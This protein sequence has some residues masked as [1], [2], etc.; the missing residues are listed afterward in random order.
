MHLLNSDK[1]YKNKFRSFKTQI[2]KIGKPVFI[3]SITTAIGFLSFMFSSL[4][5]LFRFGVITTITIFI[6]LFVIVIL[7]SLIID[8][9]INNPGIYAAENTKNNEKLRYSNTEAVLILFLL[10]KINEFKDLDKWIDILCKQQKID[11][12]W[13]NGYNSYFI[14]DIKL[15]FEIYLLISL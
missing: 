11:G 4:I 2:E 14:N 7:Y 13:T 10:N 12:R 1:L 6:S 15:F 3:T 9:N 5:P 8:F